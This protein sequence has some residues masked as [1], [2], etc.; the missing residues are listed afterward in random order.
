MI[1]SRNILSIFLSLLIF[2][3]GTQF[4]FNF[5]YCKGEL[6]EISWLGNPISCS[7]SNPYQCSL[8]E[9]FELPTVHQ[10]SCCDNQIKQIQTDT[11]GLDTSSFTGPEL[12]TS[13]VYWF[14]LERP[15]ITT[16]LTYPETYEGPPDISGVSLYQLYQQY[17]FYG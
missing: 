17:V 5:H 1:K 7:G 11:P 9:A 3:S 2:A 4:G 14:T 13:G 6:A 12:V 8:E 15:E 16:S 10:K